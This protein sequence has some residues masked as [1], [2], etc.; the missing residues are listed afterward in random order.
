VTA[1]N[2]VAVSTFQSTADAAIVK[3]ILDEAGIASMIRT[4]NAGGMYPSI[5]AVW[6]EDSSL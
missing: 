3:G 1:S 2:L 4:D 6:R 5:G